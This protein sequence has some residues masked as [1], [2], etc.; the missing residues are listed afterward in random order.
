MMIIRG[1][2]RGFELNVQ[3][4][5][6]IEKLCENEDF[7]NF[8]KLFDGKTQGENIQLD[9]RIACI[10]N[11]GYEDR[12]AY[13][14][15]SY[16]PVYLQME[17]M[18]FMKIVDVQKMEQELIKAILSG[19]ETTVE[20]EPPKPEKTAGKKTEEDDKSESD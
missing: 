1:R 17:D 2:E 7:S 19:N 11:K 10:L 18:R 9:M 12:L 6:E 3:S 8:M 13:E 4:H 16:S 20:G 15:P 5:A 14:D